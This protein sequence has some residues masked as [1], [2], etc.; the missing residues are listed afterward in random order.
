MSAGTAYR[1][2]PTLTMRSFMVPDQ[3][4]AQRVHP[5]KES[6]PARWYVGRHPVDDLPGGRSGREDHPDSSF[7]E[8]RDVFLGD[9]AAAEHDDV[10]AVLFGEQP[11]ELGEDGVV[12]SREKGQADAVHVLLDGGGDHHVR[13]LVQAGIDHLEARVAQ[14]PGD[15]LGAPLVAVE[16]GLADQEPDLPRALHVQSCTTPS[17]YATKTSMRVPQLSPTYA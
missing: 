16:A 9:D 12:G 2:S 10:R 8:P 1:L 3:N 11:E 17:Q 13:G 4:L 6:A 14:R 15:D 5:V 7:P